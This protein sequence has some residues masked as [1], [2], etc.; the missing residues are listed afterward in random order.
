MQTRASIMATPVC[1]LDEPSAASVKFEVDIVDPTSKSEP[2]VQVTSDL[3]CAVST[4]TPRDFPNPARIERRMKQ[5]NYP[6]GTQPRTGC[7]A[8]KDHCIHSQ[9]W[10]IGMKSEN[11]VCRTGNA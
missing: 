11:M 10:K 5:D 2:C 6:E 3:Y 9:P 4:A 7:S 1:P 8:P